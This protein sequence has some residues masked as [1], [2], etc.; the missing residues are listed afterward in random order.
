M[1]LWKL[2]AVQDIIH[3]LNRIADVLETMEKRS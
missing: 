2:E 3:A 1:K